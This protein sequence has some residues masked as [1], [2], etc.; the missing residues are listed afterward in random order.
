MAGCNNE[1][2]AHDGNNGH[3][4]ASNM[5]IIL[6]LLKY[7]PVC[8]THFHWKVIT[9]V[10]NDHFN[11]QIQGMKIQ[12]L[13]GAH[14]AWSGMH[15]S[16]TV[17]QDAG[18]WGEGQSRPLHNRCVG[19]SDCIRAE[20]ITVAGRNSI[21]FWTISAIHSPVTDSVCIHSPT[22]SWYALFFIHS[23]LKD[24]GSDLT[25]KRTEI[26]NGFFHRATAII[27]NQMGR[28]RELCSAEKSRL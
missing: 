1:L 16:E 2:G 12:H 4:L 14:I 5:Q 19:V 23:S 3:L 18:S 13:I 28:Y 10:L 15:D 9:Q 21:M 17:A 20:W 27:S 11:L 26:K 25:R 6:F 8:K 22:L 24:K 7:R